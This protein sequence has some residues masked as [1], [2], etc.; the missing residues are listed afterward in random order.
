MK[1]KYIGDAPIRK[2]GIDFYPGDEKTV[3]SD[4]EFDSPLFVVQKDNVNNEKSNVKNKSEK[5]KK[6]SKKGE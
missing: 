1:V 6:F 2:N 4:L 5:K 3:P